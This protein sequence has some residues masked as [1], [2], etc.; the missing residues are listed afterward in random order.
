VTTRSGSSE[1]QKC[2]GYVR[3]FPTRVGDESA[4]YF[5]R[6][7]TDGAAKPQKSIMLQNITTLSR[8]HDPDIAAPS[9]T[10]TPSAQETLWQ[11]QRSHE[12]TS[13]L[14]GYEQLASASGR[15]TV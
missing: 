13:A 8:Q 3:L 9:G 7:F 11:V 12:E 5:R 10:L 14:D 4:S 15:F 6:R 2:V 1:K